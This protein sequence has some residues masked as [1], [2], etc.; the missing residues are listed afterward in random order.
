MRTKVICTVALTVILVVSLFVPINMIAGTPEVSEGPLE[1]WSE[2]I[3]LTYPPTHGYKANID[4]YSSSFHISYE[5]WSDDTTEVYHMS[6]IDSGN[7]WSTPFQISDSGVLASWPDVGLAGN[8]V[9][10]VWGD[11]KTPAW[12]IFYRRSEDGGVTW[13]TE[14]MISSDDGHNSEGPKVFV[15]SSNVHIS[16]MDLRDGDDGEIYYRRSLNGGETFDNGQGDDSDRRITYAPAAIT[17]TR[18]AGHESNIAVTWCDRRHGNWQIYWM[19]S[20]DNGYTWEDGLG[21][22]DF[23][24]R[25]SETTSDSVVSAMAVYNSNIHIVWVEQVWPGSEPDYY[26]YY[27]RSTDNGVTWNPAQ[28]LSGPSP[29]ISNPDISVQGDEVNIVWADRIDDGENAEI[30]FKESLDGGISW[31]DDL[32]LTNATNDSWRPSI[33][34]VNNMKHVVW[35][36][37][38]DGNSEIYY[39]RSPDFGEPIPE[40]GNIVVPVVAT[41]LMVT[42]ATR[43]R[44]KKER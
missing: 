26:L 32:R 42:V 24:R 19:I 39:K 21:N 33:A 15:N 1:N 13:L 6:S 34:L 11:W 44:R 7:T 2:D 3:R 16:W 31:N 12:E 25:I 40:F 43:V 4:V 8:N 18:M 22:E 27:R 14:Q 29:I 28:Q 30:Y 37:L 38:R 5:G 17:Q 20:K 9:S 23:G 35:H 10:I 41:M 36:D